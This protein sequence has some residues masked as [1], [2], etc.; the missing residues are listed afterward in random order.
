MSLVEHLAPPK[1]ATGAAKAAYHVF[2]TI[3]VSVLPAK[4]S[5]QAFNQV[6]DH[7]EPRS[8]L[9]AAIKHM[10]PS[11]VLEQAVG[12][13]L[14]AIGVSLSLGEHTPTYINPV[15][16]YVTALNALVW[17]GALRMINLSKNKR[18][19]AVGGGYSYSLQLGVS[20]AGKVLHRNRHSEPDSAE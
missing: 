20:L 17:D 15:F 19:S 9:E 14:L 12:V 5:V 1:I 10:L 16:Y 13:G 2:G 18:P 6:P 4:Y 8:G 11:V 7:I 3:L